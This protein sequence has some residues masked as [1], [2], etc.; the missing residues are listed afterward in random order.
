MDFKITDDEIRQFYRA[1][2]LRSGPPG[3][4]P[5]L[6]LRFNYFSPDDYYEATISK[7]VVPGCAWA[8]VGCGRDIFPSFPERAQEL[9]ARAGYVYGIDPDPNIK[10]N[11][12]INDGFQGPVEDCPVTRPFD[13]ITLRM[14]AEHIAQPDRVLDRIAAMTKP[15]ALVVV[16]TPNKWSPMS[17]GAAILPFRMHHPLKHLLWKT[18]ERDTFPTVFKLNTRRDLRR[19]FGRHGF[20]EV[21]FQY[22]DDCRVFGRYRWLT[23]IDLTCR[24]VLHSIGRPHLEN[25][26]FGIFQKTSASGNGGS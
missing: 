26:L 17:L 2:Y 24:T 20:T 10:Q 12:L 23:Y 5:P 11:K 3:W 8:D 25:C 6:R 19:C 18:E 13:L 16:Y 9:A 21:H 1:K 22:L 15:G 7:L 4:G 14:V